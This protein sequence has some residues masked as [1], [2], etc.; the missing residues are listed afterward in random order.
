MC[1]LLFAKG[2]KVASDIA[3]MK[4]VHSLLA[5][6]DLGGNPT[7]NRNPAVFSHGLDRF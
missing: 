6:R 1:R 4:P 3:D 2:F 7:R 5:G